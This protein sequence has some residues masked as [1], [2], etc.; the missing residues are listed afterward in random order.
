MLRGQ[1]L[2]LQGLKEHPGAFKIPWEVA[3]LRYF[4]LGIVRTR[5]EEA[6]GAQGVPPIRMAVSSITQTGLSQDVLEL[7]RAQ[8]CW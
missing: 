2:G 3:C 5:T 8:P 6:K 1:A 4:Y 7:Y